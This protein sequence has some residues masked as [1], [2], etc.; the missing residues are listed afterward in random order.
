MSHTCPRCKR[1]F[2]DRVSACP[3]CLLEAELPPAL[4]GPYLELLDE[5]GHGGMGTVWRARDLRLDREVA[6]KIL[7]PAL[8]SEPDAQKRF[9]REARALALLSHPGIVAVHDVG[10]EGDQ[11]YIVM[12]LVSGS[13]LARLLPVPVERAC[14]IAV[15]LCEAL[16]YA[17]SKGLVHRDVKPEN[18]LIDAGGHAK[19]TDFGIARASAAGTDWTVTRAGLAVGTPQY[20]AP[21]SLA[22][23]APEPRMDVYSV[24]VVLSQMIVGLNPV[25]DFAALPPGIARIVRRA[26]A[27]EPD[28]R[29]PSAEALRL[30]LE[31]LGDA[32]EELTS[33][34]RSWIQAVALLLTLASAAALWA[35]VACVTPRVLP[36]LSL[37][38]I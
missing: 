13:S 38:H 12:E 21:E 24:G 36:P 20:M 19:L 5:L 28:Q 2:P 6:V 34:E 18:V 7:R 15:G 32:R 33:E 23:A 37:I 25:N 14:Q 16:A 1:A 27:A 22:G 30:D 3:V 10:Q 31:A 26:T 9:E 17:H 29:Y 35:F 4:L 8:A 11:R